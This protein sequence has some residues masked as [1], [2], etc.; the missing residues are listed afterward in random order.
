LF[1]TS[2]MANL[3]TSLKIQAKDKN[4][5]NV[6]LNDEFAFAVSLNAALGLHKGQPLSEA[7]IEQLKRD[8]EQQRA[9]NKALFFLGFR[10]RSQ[11][12][13]EQYLREKE[14]PPPVIETVVQRLLA[15]KYLD[16]ETFARLW[17]ENREHSRP[18]S[19]RALR[20]EL[21]QKGVDKTVINELVETVD[22]EAAAWAAVEAKLARWQTLE[23]PEFFKKLSGFLARRGFTYEVTRRIY[24]RALA[25]RGDDENEELI[26]D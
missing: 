19:A 10:P 2:K 12:E 1:Y 4:R 22:D 8:D 14:V 7:E 20:Y 6:F 25:E 16:D 11:A 3:I 21:Q 5:V 24:K 9:Y 26:D 15:E 18:R 13:I 17:V 23:P